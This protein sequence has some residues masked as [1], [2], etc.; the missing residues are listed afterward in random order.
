MKYNSVLFVLFIFV[1]FWSLIA[2]DT[3]NCLCELANMAVFFVLFYF[4][5]VCLFW[6][7]QLWS[8]WSVFVNWLELH[9]D[10]SNNFLFVIKIAACGFG[11]TL[12]CAIHKKIHL[13]GEN[14]TA[15]LKD[16]E[17]L[18]TDAWCATLHN[19]KKKATLHLHLVIWQT[20]LSKA[21]YNWHTKQH[22]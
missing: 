5:F 9:K 18:P 6:V 21:T 20:L 14:N 7:G 8:L 13:Q 15:V 16:T 1:L 4:L 17:P 19:E 2:V 12:E 10:Y 11:M 22:T 3:V